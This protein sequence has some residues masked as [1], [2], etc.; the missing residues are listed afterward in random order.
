[1]NCAMAPN[2]VP[3]RRA[4]TESSTYFLRRFRPR[5][6]RSLCSEVCRDPTRA[7]TQWRGH[8]TARSP[9]RR[10][11]PSPQPDVGDAQYSRVRPNCLA[12]T[13]RLGVLRSVTCRS[14]EEKA[15]RFRAPRSSVKAAIAIRLARRISETLLSLRLLVRAELEPGGAGSCSSRRVRFAE[16]RGR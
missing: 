4:N 1:M 16:T 7:R 8:R 12:P 2:R 5:V 6:R 15:T 10:N 9:D 3:I 11:C 13:G 14:T